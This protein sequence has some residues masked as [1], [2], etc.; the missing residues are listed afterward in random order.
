MKKK[1]GILG[2][3]GSIGNNTIEIILN[4][5]K[6]FDVI[7]LS[8]NTNVKKLLSQS[9]ILKPKSVIIFDKKKYIKYKKKFINKK[10]KVFNTFKDLKKNS[11]KMKIDYIMCAITGLA[12]LDSTINCIDSTK[13]VAI[14]NKE[15]IIC[16][17]NLIEKKLKFLIHLKI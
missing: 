1:I 8:T 7:F 16:A 3:T 15:S 11:L 5:K 6:D 10:I 4:N 14:A 13:T 12:G 2:S 9:L 17:W